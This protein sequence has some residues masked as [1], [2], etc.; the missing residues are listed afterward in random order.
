MPIRHRTAVLKAALLR[1]VIRSDRN[2]LMTPGSIALQ[3]PLRGLN[4]DRRF[5]DADVDPAFDVRRSY[6][7]AMVRWVAA[8]CTP[9]LTCREY[10]FIAG[11][12]PSV[13]LGNDVDST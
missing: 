9:M 2:P 1:K 7:A 11:H 13:A 3:L 8:R 4:R 6:R 10:V 12:S 5:F